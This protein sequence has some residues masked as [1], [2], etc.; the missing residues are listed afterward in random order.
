MSKGVEIADYLEDIVNAIA[1]VDEFTH[2]P[3]RTP[4]GDGRPKGTLCCEN[5]YVVS[6][7]F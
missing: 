6:L 2:K 7:Y 1:E 5:D 3:P 4:Q